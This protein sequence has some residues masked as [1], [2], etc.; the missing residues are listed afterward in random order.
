ML[1]GK[2]VQGLSPAPLTCRF[3]VSIPSPVPT[4]D[5]TGRPA[6]PSTFILCDSAR[7][8]TTSVQL[9]TLVGK[10]LCR[11]SW[12]IRQQHR[13]WSTVRPVQHLLPPEHQRTATTTQNPGSPCVK[14]HFHFTEGKADAQ[15]ST[16]E[17]A[18]KAAGEAGAG[19]G[20]AGDYLPW[21]S[22]P[23]PSLRVTL[24]SCFCANSVLLRCKWKSNC[25]SPHL[26]SLV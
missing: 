22:A 10:L 25:I 7:K 1:L 18:S 14:Y 9:R 24:P 19:L 21:G 17:G 8:N 6:G 4:V 2:S 11:V 23:L 12:I 3:S 5:G 20:T 13:S 16:S 15:T 26:W